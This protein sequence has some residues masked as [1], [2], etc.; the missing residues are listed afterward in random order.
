M[1]KILSMSFLSAVIL[2]L[3]CEPDRKY[4]YSDWDMDADERLNEDEFSSA[5]ERIGYY[6]RWDTNRDL[7]INEEEWN[8]GINDNYPDYDHEIEGVFRDWD[9]DDD[10]FLDEDE[11]LSG[12]YSL[13]DADDDGFI[14]ETEYEDSYYD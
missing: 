7:K 2:L 4:V 9:M 3:A 11:F 13:W 8:T 12:S 10:E 5:Y 1:K 6:D 14:D